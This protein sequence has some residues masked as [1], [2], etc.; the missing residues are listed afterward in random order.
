MA[1]VWFVTASG[2]MQMAEWLKSTL[3]LAC[4]ILHFGLFGLAG[5]QHIYSL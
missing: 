5:S 4:W 3:D 1:D 2:Q